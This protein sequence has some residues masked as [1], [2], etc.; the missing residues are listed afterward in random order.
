MAWQALNFTTS[1]LSTLLEASTEYWIKDSGGKLSVDGLALRIYPSGTMKFYLVKRIGKRT[2]K[3]PLGT[4][5]QIT[6]V[7]AREKARLEVAKIVMTGIDPLLQKKAN[8]AEDITLTQA[9]E[10]FLESRGIKPT[11]EKNYRKT[12]QLHL[13]DWS[14]RPLIR[15]SRDDVLKR[16]ATHSK[17]SPSSA[18]STMRLLRAIFNHADGQYEDVHGSRI[19]FDNPVNQLSKNKAWSK[20]APRTRRIKRSQFSEWFKAVAQLDATPGDYLKLLLFT[21][22]RRRE[23][24]SLKWTDIDLSNG[25]LTVSETKNGKP[26]TIPLSTSAIDVLQKRYDNRNS[27]PWVFPSTGKSGHLEE[28]KKAVAKIAELS[29]VT[30]SPHDLRRTF[31]SVGESTELSPYVIKRLVNH[32]ATDVTE[33]HYM[34]IDME[35]MRYGTQ[36]IAE[37][38]VLMRDNIDSSNVVAL[39]QSGETQR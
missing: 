35:R 7:Q 9:F 28:P 37:A 29:G 3:M 27:S 18:N 32:A 17:K 39:R 14:K 2:V 16:H 12:I 20:E 25:T 24:S 22:L 34:E 38:M 15:I 31:V 30:A 5:G 4:L 13:K 36:R 6:H 21:G 23:A 33:I 11:T 1:N 26:L 19:R 10:G 8:R